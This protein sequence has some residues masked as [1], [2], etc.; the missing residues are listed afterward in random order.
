MKA[1]WR[2]GGF[3][4]CAVAL[5]G[6]IAASAAVAASL[7]GKAKEEGCTGKPTVVQGTGLYRCPTQNGVHYFN[8]PAGAS[9]QSD[10]GGGGAA[11]VARSAPTPSTFPKVDAATQKGRDDVRRKVLTEELATEQKLLDEARAAY[12]NGAPPPTPEEKNLPQRYAERVVRL[13]QAV[14]LHEKNIEALQKELA[15]K[16]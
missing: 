1:L 9:G 2:G 12:A 8:L 13:K 11:A 7:S 6:C 10:A 3:L 15:A 5:C 14:S 4:W 16:R